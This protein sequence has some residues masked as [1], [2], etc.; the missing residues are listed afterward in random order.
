MVTN[1]QQHQ[2]NENHFGK[3]LLTRLSSFLRG[4]KLL[5]AQYMPIYFGDNPIKL[6]NTLQFEFF[7]S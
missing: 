6:T 1:L 4:P 7:I 2:T 3:R 5:G